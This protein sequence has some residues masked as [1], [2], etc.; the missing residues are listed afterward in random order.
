MRNDSSTS[1]VK[2]VVALSVLVGAL[3]LTISVEPAWAMP[4]QASTT[5]YYE[6]PERINWCGVRYKTCTDTQYEG[7]VT[8]WFNYYLEGC[9]WQCCT[10]CEE[11]C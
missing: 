10:G 11:F 6:E 9:C 3:V 5:E 4:C 2:R 1:L 8:P 7:C